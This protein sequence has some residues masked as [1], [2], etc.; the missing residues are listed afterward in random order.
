MLDSHLHSYPT[1]VYAHIS[2][3]VI[4]PKYRADHDTPHHSLNGSQSCQK[5]KSKFLKIADLLNATDLFQV[6]TLPS[7]DSFFL[8]YAIIPFLTFLFLLLLFPLFK[9]QCANKHPSTPSPKS[10]VTSSGI[11][12]QKSF[13]DPFHPEN[14]SRCLSVHIS[15]NTFT[16]HIIVW[17]LYETRNYLTFLSLG[18]SDSRYSINIFR[19]ISKW[20]ALNWCPYS[21][22]TK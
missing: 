1:Q 3:A 5:L 20:F 7:S 8:H 18:P 16:N 15:I 12:L 13:T 22:T 2:P 9:V 11:I 6:C 17:L 21:V 19:W 10:F 4:I 14:E